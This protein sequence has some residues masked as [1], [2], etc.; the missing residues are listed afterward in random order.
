MTE[1]DSNVPVPATKPPGKPRGRKAAANKK[2]SAAASLIAAL[3]FISTAQKNEGTAYQTHSRMLGHWLMAF[4]GVLSAGCKI[5][6]DLDACPHT[7]SL[8]TALTKCG[9]QISISQISQYVLS[10][11][12]DRFKVNIDCV[13]AQTLAASNPD[14]IL[15]PLNDEIK[16]GFEVCGWIAKEYAERAFRACVL[17]QAN[18]IVATDSHVMLEYWHGIDLPP[19]LMI[20]KVAVNAVLKTDK[21]LKGFGYTAEHSVTFWFEDDSYIKTQLFKDK[22]PN[23]EDIFAQKAGNVVQFHADL[24]KAIDAVSPFC[25]SKEGLPSK[26]IHFE[27]DKLCSSKNEN[28][29]ASFDLPTLPGSMTFDYELLRAIEPYFFNVVVMPAHTVA[30]QFFFSKDR[31]RGILMGAYGD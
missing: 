16:R 24:F 4:D 20:P 12:S 1:I 7:A 14:P 5:E 29:G 25:K 26:F 10:V 17:L 6:E 22:Y 19:G 23:Y 28:I 21:K 13:D 18:S 27:N 3:K 31:V 2:P 30:S 9:E 8:L 15:V 11:K